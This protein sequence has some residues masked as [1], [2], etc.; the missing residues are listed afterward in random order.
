MTVSD[1]PP[2]PD[3]L[4]ALDIFC[5][6]GGGDWFGAH[7]QERTDEEYG[8]ADELGRGETFVENPSGERERAER[9]E[10]LKCL[11]QGD[12]DL[13]NGDVI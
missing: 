8:G 2:A 11:R 13:L 9:T 4:D 6:L 7:G 5:G 10:E 12:A 3:T 1:T